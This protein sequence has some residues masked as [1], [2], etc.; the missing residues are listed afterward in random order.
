MGRFPYASPGILVSSSWILP[1]LREAS[2]FSVFSLITYK[3]LQS[4]LFLQTLLESVITSPPSHLPCPRIA[5]ATPFR[6]R[7]LHI[8][9]PICPFFTGYE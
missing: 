8:K 6:F 3:L 1:I 4:I 9:A 2:S 5:L 7:A